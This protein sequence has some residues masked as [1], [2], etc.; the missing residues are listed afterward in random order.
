M[1]FR[2]FQSYSPPRFRFPRLILALVG[3]WAC[4]PAL[5]SVPLQTDAVQIDLREYSQKGF[6]FTP[7]PTYTGRYESVGMVSVTLAAEGEYKVPPGARRGPVGEPPRWV[8]AAIDPQ[9]ALRETQQRVVAMG[10]NAMLSL[11]VESHSGD[12]GRPTM[13]VSGFAI[14]R[15]D[16]P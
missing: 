15:L 3:S 16:V 14:K 11:R 8:W 12:K 5:Q 13:N 2:M 1:E 6:L 7:D 10:G 9:R 4:A